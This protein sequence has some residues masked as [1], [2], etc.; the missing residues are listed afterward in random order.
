[1]SIPTV[2]Q[3]IIARKHQE[4]AERKQQ[5][6]VKELYAHIKNQSASR[7]FVNAIERKMAAGLR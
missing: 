6:P 3:K 7:G 1:M 5:V 2:L 4:V